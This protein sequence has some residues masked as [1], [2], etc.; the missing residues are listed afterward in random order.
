M[1]EGLPPSP[2]NPGGVREG[3]LK[4]PLLPIP[5]PSAL[6][7]YLSGLAGPVS[8]SLNS[9]IFREQDDCQ[10]RTGAHDLSQNRRVP[11]RVPSC[12]DLRPNLKS[13]VWCGPRSYFRAC[14]RRVPSCADGLPNRA[15][16]NSPT[17]SACVKNWLFLLGVGSILVSGGLV[18]APLACGR[19]R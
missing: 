18:E 12:A 1:V 10:N 16:P 3:W 14:A 8:C 5:A 2:S 19:G 7:F 15:R 13:R 4:V 9:I 6:K 11:G 17:Q